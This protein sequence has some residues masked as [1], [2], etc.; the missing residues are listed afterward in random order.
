MITAPRR[1]SAMPAA[2]RWV[3]R[4][5]RVD[6]D[7]QDRQLFLER[8]GG[9]RPGAAHARGVDQHVGLEPVL[10]GRCGEPVGGRR[11]RE[12]CRDGHAAHAVER[13]QLRGELLQRRCVLRGAP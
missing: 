13:R 9:E 11:I 1:R 4:N 12:V 8:G 3:R 6:V 7:L 10:C 2:K 5:D